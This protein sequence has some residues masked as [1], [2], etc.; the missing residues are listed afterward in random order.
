MDAGSRWP[1]RIYH[2]ESR[3]AD[4]EV[5]V[6]VP[7]QIVLGDSELSIRLAEAGVGIFYG[8]RDRMTNELDSDALEVVLEDWSYVTPGFHAYYTSHRQV[9]TA[10]RALLDHLKSP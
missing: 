1:D 6:D 10:L 4:R 7:G 9:P 2:W 5:R 3:H 8:L